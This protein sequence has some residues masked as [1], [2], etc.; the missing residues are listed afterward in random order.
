LPPEKAV[1]NWL[2][3]VVAAA[4]VDEVVVAEAAPNSSVDA[5]SR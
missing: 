4:P 3:S 1:D 2:R 5:A